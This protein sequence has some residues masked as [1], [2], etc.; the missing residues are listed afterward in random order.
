MEKNGFSMVMAI[1][2]RK[3]PREWSPG[4]SSSPALQTAVQSVSPYFLSFLLWSNVWIPLCSPI[5]ILK[6]IPTR[7]MPLSFWKR[8]EGVC[9]SLSLPEDMARR[10]TS[11][12]EWALTMLRLSVPWT[13]NFQDWQEFCF[14]YKLLSLQFSVTATKNQARAIPVA[15]SSL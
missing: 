3:E 5:Y 8:S 7:V 1:K 6:P 2:Q 4:L 11:Y 14:C 10:H 12:E 15:S 13:S 9:T